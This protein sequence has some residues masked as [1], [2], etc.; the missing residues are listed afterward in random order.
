MVIFCLAL[1]PG[2]SPDSGS[3]SGLNSEAKHAIFSPEQERSLGNSRNEFP[4]LISG[5]IMGDFSQDCCTMYHS[6]SQPEENPISVTDQV[7]SERRMP[8]PHEAT[9]FDSGLKYGS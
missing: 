8:L 1:I 6:P 9:S 5:L 3:D 7:G 4:H 2:E